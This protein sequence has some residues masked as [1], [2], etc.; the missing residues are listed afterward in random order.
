MAAVERLV[1]G[2]I[3]RIRV[4]VAAPVV[5]VK[6]DSP[7]HARGGGDAVGQ[8][9]EL[10]NA[11][12]VGDSCFLVVLIDKP[13]EVNQQDTRI[14]ATISK[15]ED[16][17]VGS[18]INGAIGAGSNEAAVQAPRPSAQR[19]MGPSAQEAARS[20]IHIIINYNILLC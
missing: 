7:Q 12:N 14:D 9:G 3:F 13:A 6:P 1:G 8:L 19:S 17:A 15:D 5:E 2:G 4:V 10:R 18:A 11:D 16:E 20:S